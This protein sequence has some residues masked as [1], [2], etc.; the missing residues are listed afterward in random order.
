[1]RTPAFRSAAALAVL[2]LAAAAPA[3]AEKADREKPVNIGAD[4]LTADDRNR[5]STFDGNVVVT[6]GTLRMTAARVT[7]REDAQG[8]KSYVATGAPVSFRQKRDQAEDWVEGWA[9]RAE[10]DDRTDMLRLVSRARLKSVQGEISGELITYDMG[11]ELFQV[12]GAP[13]APGAEAGGSSRVKAT[14]L[15]TKKGA[16]EKPAP[17]VKLKPD[18]GPAAAG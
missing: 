16:P 11:K 4:Q 15:P 7:V 13:G 12:T 1:M 8:F 5:T 6:Q 14:L 10:F 3:A 18:A 9:E 17:P 2:A